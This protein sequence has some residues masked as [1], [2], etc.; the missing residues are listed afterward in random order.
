VDDEVLPENDNQLVL[1]LA[2]SLKLLQDINILE[3]DEIKQEAIDEQTLSPVLDSINSAA[4]THMN[5]KH[6][7]KL[8]TTREMPADDASA[9]NDNRP[10]ESAPGDNNEK[11]TDRGESS[12]LFF[13]CTPTSCLFLLNSLLGI[14]LQNIIFLLSINYYK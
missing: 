6:G 13:S 3:L 12:Y 2:L 4:N 1:D 8:A 5:T 7:L 9:N 10:S 11:Q 14:S